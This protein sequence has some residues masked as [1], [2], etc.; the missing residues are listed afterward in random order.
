MLQANGD[1]FV[2]I[3]MV[4]DT[5]VGKSSL[6]ERF[7]IDSCL[8]KRC[9]TVGMDFILTSMT[10]F[11]IHASVQFWDQAGNERY[12][13]RTRAYYG[14]AH[15]I[16]IMYDVTN[17]ESFANVSTKWLE[18][19]DTYK[20]TTRK[21]LVGNKTDLETLRTVKREDGQQLANKVGAQFYEISTK[22]GANCEECMM[23]IISQALWKING[24]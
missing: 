12:R 1:C 19:I 8:E 22:T 23:D 18:E 7:E 20:L 6:M 21:L 10:V 24:Q 11:G 5:F 9:L 3:V 15:W 14:G 17:S 4:G 2:K 13:S 16:I